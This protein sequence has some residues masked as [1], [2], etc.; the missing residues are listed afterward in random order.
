[1]KEIKEIRKNEKFGKATEVEVKME[2][3]EGKKK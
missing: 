1:M 3:L 2:D